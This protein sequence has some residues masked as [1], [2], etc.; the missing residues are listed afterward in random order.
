MSL[1]RATATVGSLT[2]VSRVLGFLRDIMLASTLGAGMVADCFVMAFK[3]PNFFRRMFAEGAFSA[4]FLPIFSSLIEDQTLP[5]EE[6]RKQAWAFAEEA[7]AF[8]LCTLLIFV[9]VAEIFMPWVMMGPALGFLDDKPKY[10]L[11][12]YLTR[13][14]FPYLLFISLT[15]LL[16]GVLNA[17]GKFAA[18]AFTPVL[19]NGTM[20]LSLLIGAHYTDAPAV[21]LS[22]GVSLAGVL[23]FLWLWFALKRNHIHMR[24]IAPHLTPGVKRLLKLILPAALGAGAFQVNLLVDVFLAGFLK[25]GS[26]S[27]LYYADRINQLPL[28]V[29]GVAV[30]TALLPLLSRQVAAG[31]IGGAMHSQNRA[32]EMSLFLTLPAAAAI[33]A[34][35]QPIIRV[36]FERN[37][38]TPEVT[39]AT[40]AALSAFAVGLP[41]YVLAKVL[42]PG[43]F[44]RQDT[45][46]PVRYA[47]IS[48]VVNFLLNVALIFPLKH[49]GIA[50][51]TALAA[52]I[53]VG[54]LTYG[55]IRRD[56]FAID[57]RLK[58]SLIGITLSSAVM[59][60]LVWYVSTLLD[61]P[62][63]GDSIAKISA[64]LGLILLGM[65]SYG[66]MTLATG[67]I[68]LADLKKLRRAKGKT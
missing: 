24:L 61:A 16:G 13:L 22:I 3:F 35:S 19:L 1:F 60:L 49:V 40:A 68:A 47:M 45:T 34:L 64:L 65:V 56:Y 4:A 32:I 10:D 43:F 29:V 54:Q 27:Y 50:L 37:A 66:V 26:L 18:M 55:L 9:A 57:A 52:W 33:I 48:L 11:A 14:T 7:M 12:V 6:R 58:K 30:G 46:T 62:L 59:G 53:N 38:F 44:A 21:A 25:S 17:T 5:E 28:G 42:T 2:L 36:L 63:H 41:A 23:Q 8:L 15:S 31:N 67:S 20:I 39:L 51:A